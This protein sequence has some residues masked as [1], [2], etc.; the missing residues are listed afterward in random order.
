M[1]TQKYEKY[2]SI[3]LA[4]TNIHG[5]KFNSVL[6]AIVDF[7]DNNNT[8]VYNSQLYED[9]QKKVSQINGLIDISLRK[10]INQFVKLGFINFELKSYHPLCKLYLSTRVKIQKRTIFSR[11]V[12]EN[13]SFNRDVT[14]NSTNREINFLLK[15]LDAVGKLTTEDILALMTQDINEY[16]KGYLTREEIDI[17]SKNSKEIEFYSRKYNQVNHFKSCVLKNLDDLVIIDNELYFEDDAKILFGEDLKKETKKRD[18]YLHR[19]YK[20]QLAEESEAYFDQTVKCMVEKLPYP[21]LVAS[22]IKPFIESDDNE[23]Y[24]PNNGLLLSRNMDILFDQGYISFDDNGDIIYSKKLNKEIVHH[25]E[26]YKLCN[27]FINE[28]RKKYFDYHRKCVLR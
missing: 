5:E 27:V 8:T 6:G 10:S 16:E 3:T 14:K 20:N 13:S 22:H 18:N 21:S 19:I 24:D 9:L 15:T 25:L 7:I 17:A 4:Y 2:W 1:S 11:I 12:Y 28:S 23:A 26:K